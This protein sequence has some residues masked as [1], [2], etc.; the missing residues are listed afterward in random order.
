MA[1][2]GYWK[3]PGRGGVVAGLLSVA[4]ALDHDLVG[5][6]LAALALEQPKIG[7]Q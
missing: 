4:G 6:F 3:V 7:G 1:I 5:S 2:R